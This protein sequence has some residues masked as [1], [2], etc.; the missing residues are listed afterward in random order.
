MS[1]LVES[2]N[3][4]RKQQEQQ[5]S[6]H[7]ENKDFAENSV[8]VSSHR[9]PHNN[10]KRSRTTTAKKTQKNQNHSS[11]RRKTSSSDAVTPCNE[12]KKII[13]KKSKNDISH[14]SAVNH[15]DHSLKR[16]NS[17]NGHVP[18]TINQQQLTKNAL[19]HSP[20]SILTKLDMKALFQ[21]SVFESLP[22]HFQLKVIKLLPECDRQVDSTGSFK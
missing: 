9:E 15:S 20:T 10:D 3:L 21:P 14:H 4:R 22:R 11:N 12:T 16:S 13:R 8:A 6:V 17:M 5:E 1:Y 2:E 7:K 18:I 19:F